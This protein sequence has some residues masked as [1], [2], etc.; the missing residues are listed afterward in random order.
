MKREAEVQ[1][2][3]HHPS[4][5]KLIGMVLE[6]RQCGLVLEYLK[7]GNIMGLHEGLQGRLGMEVTDEFRHRPWHEL[8][9]H[10][11]AQHCSW[12]SDEPEYPDRRGIQSEGELLYNYQ[13]LPE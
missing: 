6:D 8:S 1:I 3:L 12:G 7:Y 13:D 4:I 9:A 10:A 11:D 2:Q 5:E